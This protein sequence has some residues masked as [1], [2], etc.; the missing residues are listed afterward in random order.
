[1]YD[2]LANN[3]KAVGEAIAHNAAAGAVGIGLGIL[4]TVALGSNP[5][6]WATVA[7]AAGGSL[8]I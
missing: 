8:G 5:A 1:M 7:I 6:G 3:D 2:D 4:T